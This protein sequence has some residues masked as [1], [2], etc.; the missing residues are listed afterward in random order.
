MSIKYPAMYYEKQR[1]L[2]KKIQGTGN[3]VYRTM[4]PQSPSK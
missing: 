1:H 4:T 3:I 2:L